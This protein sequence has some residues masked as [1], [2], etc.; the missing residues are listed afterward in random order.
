MSVQFSYV[1]LYALLCSNVLLSFR[2]KEML[3]DDSRTTNGKILGDAIKQCAAIG[4]V[5]RGRNVQ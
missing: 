4:S 5:I 2:D 3:P 1:V